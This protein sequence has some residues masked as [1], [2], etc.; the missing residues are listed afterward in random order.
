M[1]VLIEKLKFDK[2]VPQVYLTTTDF[3]LGDHTKGYYTYQNSPHRT[4]LIRDLILDDLKKNDIYLGKHYGVEG[5]PLDSLL[6]DDLSN[7]IIEI[8]MGHVQYYNLE[9]LQIL[10]HKNKIIFVDF[11]E[12][13]H[14]K[15]KW[16][17]TEQRLH[18]DFFTDFLKKSGLNL[19][20]IIYASNDFI[21]NRLCKE[22]KFLHFW[23]LAQ[24]LAIPYIQ[25]IIKD[26][27][28]YNHYLDL[29]TNKQYSEFAVFRNWQAR[30]QRLILLSLLHKNDSLKNID[31]SLVGEFGHY[32]HDSKELKFSMK[33]HFK[34]KLKT[35]KFSLDVNNFFSAYNNDLPKFLYNSDSTTKHAKFYLSPNDFKKYRYSIDVESG[36]WVSE[37]AI[38]GCIQGSM[39]IV[40]YP[41]PNG[42]F[43]QLSTAMGFKFLDLN[44]DGIQDL[45]ELLIDASQK[46]KMLHDNNI[47]PN[48]DDV[49]HNFNMCAD[50]KLLASY[51]VQPLVDAFGLG[52]KYVCT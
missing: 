4:D 30:P 7:F 42:N 10:S 17:D 9:Q 45:N 52:D 14:I 2:A 44:F 35:G 8:P 37:K 41:Y 49:V 12:S 18:L 6:N 11:E 21:K 46:I 51:I 40:V 24:S 13:G 32:I 39:P 25:E 38:K 29:L 27:T 43:S 22:I 1:S 47:Q 15:F 28:T 48:I 26:N 31:W 36:N 50:K 34:E 33:E 5:V 20:N 19:E 16:H 3:V 23:V